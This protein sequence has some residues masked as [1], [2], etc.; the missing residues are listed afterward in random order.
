MEG[1]DFDHWLSEYRKHKISGPLILNTKEDGLESYC[2]ER[3]RDQDIK[4]YFFL[5]TT[6]PTL[7][8]W[9]LKKN[10]PN[11][12]VRFSAYEPLSSIMAF[13]TKTSW[14][15]IDCFDGIPPD[16][17]HV[18]E[19]KKFF[20]ICLVSP[21]LQVGMTADLARLI[22]DFSPVLSLIDAVCTKNPDLWPQ[23][24]PSSRAS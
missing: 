20:R 4:N 19:L 18:A 24:S 3:L 10:L 7:V 14:V 23:E 2:L 16:P 11:F 17:R 15:W 6:I 13:A 5:D 8:K 22:R 1:D 9:T 21:E 12:A